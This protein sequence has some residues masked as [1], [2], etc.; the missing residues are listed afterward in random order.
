MSFTQSLAQTLSDKHLL[1]HPFYQAWTEGSIPLET[2]RVYAAQYFQHVSAF[3]R[4]LSA[5]HSDCTNIQA[6]QL[7]LEN[8]NDEE[9]GTENHPELWLRFLEGLGGQRSDALQCAHVLPQTRALVNTFL[10]R[11]KNSYA[12][13]LGVLFAYERQVPEVAAFKIDALKAKYGINDEQ[14]L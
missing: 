14:T 11:A 10:S 6:R 13:G 4:Y 1:Q 9:S 12:E 7:L 2:L 5:T 3:P 8:L